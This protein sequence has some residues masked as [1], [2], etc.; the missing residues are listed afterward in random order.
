M[1][2]SAL[3]TA[4]TVLYLLIILPLCGVHMPMVT[5]LIPLTF[6]A[7]LIPVV[8][9]LISNAAIVLISLGMSPGTAVASLVFLI[10]IHKL[11]YFTNARIIGGE[12]HAGAWE[13]LCAM[14]AM[15]AVFGVAGLVAAPV[16]YAWLKAE[17]KARG[18]I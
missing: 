16:A 3:N 13:L 7:G 5:I 15:E 2:I 6:I 10:A 1:K 12:V 14:L 11:E 18:M 17:L 4:L 9:N 8:G